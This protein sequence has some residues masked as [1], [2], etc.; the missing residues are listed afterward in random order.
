[1]TG[2]ASTECVSATALALAEE[3][4]EDMAQRW[5]L[6]ERPRTED[7]LS[8][9]PELEQVP[10]AVLELISEEICLRQEH[11]E[12][13]LAED[14]Q[15]RFPRWGPQVRALLECHRVLGAGTGLAWFPEPGAT[16]GEF[17]LLVELGRGSQA[18]AFLARQPALAGRLVVLKLGP[19]CGQEHLSLARLQHTHIVPLHSVHQFSQEGLRGLCQPYFGG[20]PLSVLLEKMCDCPPRKRTGRDLLDALR[21]A[22]RETP[23]ALPIDGPVCRMLARASYPQAV[24][25]LGACLADALHYAH[26]RGVVHL[27]LKP[28]NV[29][30]AADGQPMLLDFHLARGP[31]PAGTRAA[32]WLGGTPGYMAPEQEAALRAVAAGRPVPISVDTRADVYALGTLLCEL[33]GGELPAGNEQAGSETRQLNPQVTRGLADLLDRCTATDPARRYPTAASLAADLRRHLADQPLHGVANRSPIEHWHKW[34]RRRPSALPLLVLLLAALTA[35]GILVADVTRQTRQARAAL[36]EGRDYLDQHRYAE[37][38]DALRHGSAL[39]A[40]LPFAPGLRHELAGVLRLAEHA[41]AAGELHRLC[42][43]VRPLYAIENLGSEQTRSVLQQCDRFWARRQQIWHELR[44]QPD[45]GL[46]EQVRAD[47]LDL[48]ILETHLRVR[49]TPGGEAHREALAVLA[50]ARRLFG[51]SCVLCQERRLHTRAL[52]LPDDE[53]GIAVSSPVSAR[54]RRVPSLALGLVLSEH[55]VSPPV[56]AW[57]HHALG[58]AYLLAGDLEQALAELDRALELQPQSLWSSFYRGCCAYRLGQ[59]DDAVVSFSVCLALA[60]ESAWCFH[61][62]GLAYAELGRVEL[63]LRDQERALRLDPSLAQSI[64]AG[65]RRVRQRDPGNQRARLLLRQLGHL[66]SNP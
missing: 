57:E 26:E 20:A 49:L 39:A 15:R 16:L 30:L 56:S 25:W 24:C 18:R 4:A 27:D 13:L 12:E 10:E 45:P 5:R 46:R 43:R 2:P 35:G 60:P 41:G 7:C 9:H 36:E 33:L 51:P 8:I 48:G 19:P 32:A 65:V 34:R 50:E 21:A 55:A 64:L 38:L 17:E 40:H 28:S 47:L 59:Y 6:G 63:A 11:G 62:R 37:A 23:E 31:L 52:K 58:R 53:S 44:R 54:G 42:E 14:F 22:Q 29:L 1:V 3:L 66:H 61:N